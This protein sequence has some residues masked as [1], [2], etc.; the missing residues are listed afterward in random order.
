L[1]V[2]VTLFPGALLL[3][4]DEDVRT[5]EAR[6]PFQAP[7][8]S[9]SGQSFGSI[10]SSGSP[11]VPQTYTK[12]N[13]FV[14]NPSNSPRDSPAV[15]L[16]EWKAGDN[17][18]LR[19]FANVPKI[20]AMEI[21]DSGARVYKNGNGT[22]K[23]GSSGIFGTIMAAPLSV[24]GS[25]YTHQG[26]NL[27]KAII[28]TNIS[29]PILE[30][31]RA[32]P[33][34]SPRKKSLFGRSRSPVKQGVRKLGISAPV[35]N[36][37]N[38]L[39]VAPF[40][41]MQTVD[42]A[43]AAASERDRRELIASRQLIAD[44]PAPRPPRFG[45]AEGLQK[46]ISTRRKEI[47]PIYAP[48][49]A[50]QSGNS[51]SGLSVV[52]NASSTSASL[53]PGRDDIRRRSPR[54]TSKSFDE[55]LSNYNISDVSRGQTRTQTRVEIIPESRTQNPLHA[56]AA[57]DETVMFIKDIVYDQPGMV[58]SIISGVPASAAKRKPEKSTPPTP[59][60]GSSASILHR[61]RPYK[62]DTD[63]ERAIFPSSPSPRHK[64]SKSG[65]SIMA[66][67]SI[68]QSQ[69]GS[70]SGLPPLPPPPTSASRL[71]RLLPNDTRSMTVDEK[72][73]LLFPAPSSKHL[74]KQRRSSVPSIPRIPSLIL[75]GAGLGLPSEHSSLDHRASKRSTISFGLPDDERNPTSNAVVSGTRG[76]DTY[77]FSA[78]TYGDLV[79][80]PRESWLTGVPVAIL[81]GKGFWKSATTTTNSESGETHEDARSAWTSLHSPVPAVEIKGVR[82][83]AIHLRRD[84]PVIPDKFRELPQLPHEVKDE[85]PET[86]ETDDQ[87][88]GIMTFML[89][90]ENHPLP[91]TLRESP[92]SAEMPSYANEKVLASVSEQL[93]HY[94]LGDNLPTFSTRKVNFRARAMAPPTPLLLNSSGRKAAVVVREPEPEV[95]DSPGRAIKQIQAQLKNF[96]E[97]DRNSLGSI[98][99]H[100]PTLVTKT[101]NGANDDRLAMLANLE[102]EM[103][104]QE[105]H[106]MEMQHNFDRDSN[107]TMIPSPAVQE[108]QARGHPSP[109]SENSSR[110]S[111]VRSVVRRPRIRSGTTPHSTKT[112]STLSSD[113]SKA[114]MWQQRLAE[115]QMMF[116]ENAPSLQQRSN[117][118]FLHLQKP[119]PQPGS[120][121]PPESIDSADDSTQFDSDS[122]FEEEAELFTRTPA[123]KLVMANLWE[124]KQLAPTITVG[125][126]WVAS[127]ARNVPRI[128]SPEP[129]AKYVRPATRKSDQPMIVESSTL[130]SKPQK[131]SHISPVG[132]WGTKL[133]RPRSIITRPK[134]QRP[135]RKS[136]RMTFLPDI[137]KLP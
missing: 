21:D 74:I 95:I 20:R 109:P 86:D 130:W 33:R 25:H 84:P 116:T 41:R 48:T 133:S 38:S 45:A 65:S 15:E 119:L 10:A 89:A 51:V 54:Q 26:L 36:E 120:P 72:I 39:S 80:E 87:S 137:G 35:I 97:S 90:T 104:R 100:M 34:S 59:R 108:L 122:E 101:P 55:G 135:Q 63:T 110:R 56:Q 66:R 57:N 78:N 106:W 53:S 131:T 16:Q 19:K 3:P 115:A 76:N 43:T 24:A 124:P 37:T 83:N 126:M 118:N 60:S 30:Q 40:A 102:E 88:T 47:K 23:R 81:P 94:K 92:S 123:S 11:I 75:Q 114:G 61:P 44:R 9:Q 12:G 28:S 125:H 71:Q 96:E 93:W 4:H 2:I 73:L 22:A 27:P 117:L 32:V 42:L 79:E 91:A 121:T 50:S 29:S 129:A 111:S 6:S 13:F 52:A 134:A 128:P 98:I 127:H 49:L 58:R 62:R 7:S 136:R 107:S 132:L 18:G 82:A 67:K 14:V 99:H 64:R 113:V 1:T 70:P 69:P 77:R 103:G 17:D 68:I 31:S 85:E 105:S 112:G 46:S 8:S 5:P